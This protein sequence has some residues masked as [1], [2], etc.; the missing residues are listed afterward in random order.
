MKKDGTIP[1]PVPGL[2]AAGANRRQH[3]SFGEGDN[4]ITALVIKL[5]VAA[6]TDDQN[7]RPC[8]TEPIE[9]NSTVR[10]DLICE[11]QFRSSFI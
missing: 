2:S 10:R 4:R 9:S 6:G 8:K 7:T 3:N 5:R 1:G 11:L